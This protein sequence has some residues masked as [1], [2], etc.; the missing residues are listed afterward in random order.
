[1][2]GVGETGTVEGT[3]VAVTDRAVLVR[4]SDDPKVEEW[5]PKSKCEELY[6]VLVD[7]QVQFECPRWLMEAKGL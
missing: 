6:G 4:I 7:E 2:S 3:A 1:M 5:F